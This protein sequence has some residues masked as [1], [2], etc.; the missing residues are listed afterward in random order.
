MIALSLAENVF[1]RERALQGAV[2]AIV[3]NGAV[4]GSG[5]II[6]EDEDIR[7]IMVETDAVASGNQRVAA[8]NREPAGFHV[9]DGSRLIVRAIE[10]ARQVERVAADIYRRRLLP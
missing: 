3:G 2:V 6:L 7:A 5:K 8:D 4:G 1:S 9:N 10:G